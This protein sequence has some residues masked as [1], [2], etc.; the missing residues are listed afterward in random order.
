MDEPLLRGVF[1][2]PVR[3]RL[4]VPSKGVPGVST[5]AARRLVKGAGQVLFEGALR[6]AN[7]RMITADASGGGARVRE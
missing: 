4:A 3:W 6:N 7:A 1:E 2:G 5:L